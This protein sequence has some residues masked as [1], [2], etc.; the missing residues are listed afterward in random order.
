MESVGGL[1][2]HRVLFGVLCVIAVLLAAFIINWLLS[3]R[4]IFEYTAYGKIDRAEV[5]TL[6]TECIRVVNGGSALEVTKAKFVK[7]RGLSEEVVDKLTV[8]KGC[9]SIFF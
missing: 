2:K 8:S 7:D 6:E 5:V 1:T 9:E 3:D 4:Y